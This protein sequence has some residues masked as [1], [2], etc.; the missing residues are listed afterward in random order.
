MQNQLGIW[1]RLRSYLSDILLFFIWEFTALS[2]FLGLPFPNYD[3]IP[4]ADHLSSLTWM[5]MKWTVALC[6]ALA[7]FF[8]QCN[9]IHHGHHHYLFYIPLGIQIDCLMQL[10]D[11]EVGRSSA[12][13]SS[14]FNCDL[15]RTSNSDISGPG[16]SF[17]HIYSYTPKAFY[18][19]Y[20]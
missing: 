5:M 10:Y 3:P 8:P 9:K 12:S 13:K 19:K 4:N 17:P 15:L 11:I 20:G 16:V 1:P 14:L 6:F 7:C 2:F 18:T